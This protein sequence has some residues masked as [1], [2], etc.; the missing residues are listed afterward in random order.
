MH[1]V[2]WI[3][4]SNAPSASPQL[5]LGSPALAQLTNYALNDR[6]P[7][8]PVNSPTCFTHH[9]HLNPH[10]QFY[11]FPIIKKRSEKSKRFDEKLVIVSSRGCQ[12]QFLLFCV[13][14]HFDRAGCTTPWREDEAASAEASMLEISFVE[15]Q[16]V[17]PILNRRSAMIL[18]RSR[19]L[20]KFLNKN[21]DK[22]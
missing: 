9:S 13:G 11:T 19:C 14:G 1:R 6:M 7:E 22:K 18:R 8:I 15:S 10:Q 16:S 20:L 21:Q 17:I 12:S 2:T 3:T 4:Y 5:S